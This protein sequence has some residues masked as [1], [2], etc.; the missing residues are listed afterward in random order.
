MKKDIVKRKETIFRNIKLLEM[1]NILIIII[2]STFFAGCG[3]FKPATPPKVFYCKINGVEF[4][5]ELDNSPIGGVGSSPLKVNRDLVNG[6]FYIQAVNRP[7]YV[8]L[9]IKL[10]PN[11]DLTTGEYNLK[12]ELNSS[13]GVYSYNSTS[14][15]SEYLNSTSGK[16]IITKIE[17]TTIW[18]TFE[19][20]TKST[21]TNTDYIISKGEIIAL[22]Y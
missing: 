7:N 13:S 19:F 11:T 4:V 18:G 2:F 21:K 20:S 15:Q 22:R 6:W 1:K 14:S 12:T 5:P 9:R 17:G 8:S 3:W 16:L 10:P